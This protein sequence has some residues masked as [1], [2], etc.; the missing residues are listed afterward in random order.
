VE[1]G[2]SPL[3]GPWRRWSLGAE[4]IADQKRHRRYAISPQSSVIPRV[5]RAIGS[6]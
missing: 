2:R 6:T 1:D 3:R 5:K 4:A